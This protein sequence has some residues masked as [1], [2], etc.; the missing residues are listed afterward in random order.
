MTPFGTW[1][2]EV[3]LGRYDAVFASNGVIRSLSDADLCELDLTLGDR[4]RLLQAVARLD[5]QSAP[6]LSPRRSLGAAS[7]HCG[8]SAPSSRGPPAGSW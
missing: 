7:R 2:A 1:L 8:T 3:G 6:T 4:K 5:E